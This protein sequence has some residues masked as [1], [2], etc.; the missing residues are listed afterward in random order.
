MP[1]QRITSALQRRYMWLLWLA[2]L[3]PLAQTAAAWHAYSHSALEQ[4]Q[5]GD[6]KQTLHQTHCDLCLTAAAVSGGAL[7]TAQLVLPFQTANYSLPRAAFKGV[8]LALLSPAYSPRA[9]PSL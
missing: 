7:P 4:S 5:E 8:W 3:L 2:L 1:Q 9:P 6:T